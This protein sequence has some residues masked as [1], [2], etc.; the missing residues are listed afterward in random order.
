[1]QIRRE[2]EFLLF[3]LSTEKKSWR[4]VGFLT[5]VLIGTLL[6]AAIVS[7]GVYW[8]VT[9]WA[10]AAPNELNLYLADKD[11]PRYFDRL[12]W[13]S[14]IL[15]LPWLLKRCG[16]L[17]W[18]SLGYTSNRRSWLSV[19][20][21]FGV[22]LAMLAIVAIVQIFTVGLNIK[23]PLISGEFTA[24]LLIGIM[25]GLI[26][27]FVE[28][29]VFRGLVFRMFYTALSPFTAV[30]I[31]ALLFAVLHF[32]KVPDSLWMD[33]SV[34]LGSGF[35]VGFW[36]LL[37]V[38]TSFELLKFINL[39]FAG[40]ILNSLFLKSRSLLPCIGLHAGWV[41]FRV[42]YRKFVETDNDAPVFIWGS[43]TVIDGVF[44][45]F[46]MG[47]FVLALG[48]RYFHTSNCNESKSSV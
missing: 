10:K 2:R 17:S 3:G 20:N 12:R 18:T 9:G 44:P 29:T 11:F 34:S 22:G 21:W 6:I 13:M 4:G 41:C 35:Y 14:V 39:F 28:E 25:S 30:V 48:Y 1:M 27:A 43:E 33:N 38:I 15:L 46:I 40:L 37:S 23:I 26:V 24:V 19:V 7:P 45:S 8:G 42:V 16:L 32:K 31:S 5:V 47:I 36:V